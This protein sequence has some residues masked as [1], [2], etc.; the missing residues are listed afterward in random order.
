MCPWGGW[1][2]R[3]TDVARA[4]IGGKGTPLIRS[5]CLLGQAAELPGESVLSTTSGPLWT[6]LGD[7]ALRGVGNCRY[8]SASLE[9]TNAERVFYGF[10]P[11]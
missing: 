5:G 8:L 11:I 9:N 7:K 2:P 1:G 3:H 6:L 10:G 4:H